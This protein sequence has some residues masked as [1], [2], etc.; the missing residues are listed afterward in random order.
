MRTAHDSPLQDF[1]IRA[2]SSA[3]GDVPAAGQS[4]FSHSYEC[5]THDLRVA[6]QVCDTIVVMQNGRIVESGPAALV[7]TAPQHD[8]TRSLIEIAPGRDW[9]FQNFR[10]V[11][12]NGN[13]SIA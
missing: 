8:Y 7:L 4:K 1:V 10:P 2:L 3:A 12:T 6:A 13:S 5:I 11:R 9:D